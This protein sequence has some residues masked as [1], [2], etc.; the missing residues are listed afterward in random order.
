MGQIAQQLASNSQASGTLP[1]GTVTNPREHNTVNVVTTRSGKS[2]EENDIE[3][4]GLIEVDLEIKETKNQ[5][6]EVIPP[7]VKEKEKVPKP[8]APEKSSDDD[9]RP[10]VQV[11]KNPGQPRSTDPP[12]SSQSKKSKKNKRSAATEPELT[13]QPTQP[14][15][16]HSHQSKGHQGQKRKKHDSLSRSGEAKKKKHH[17]VLTLEAPSLDADTIVVDTSILNKVPDLA[18]GTSKSTI[19]PFAAVLE[20]ENP[21]VVLP[22][23]T[24][25]DA[26]G[27]PSHHVADYTPSSPTS[28]PSHQA[29]S[30]VTAGE[31][32]GFPIQISDSDSDSVTSPAT[33]MFSSSTSSDSSL[34]SASLPLQDSRGPR[35]DGIIKTQPAQT[36]PL[37]TTSPSSSQGL[38]IKPL[39]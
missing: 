19:T 9:E 12:V 15:S 24:Q 21:D 13:P 33:H 16:Q 31:F 32:I 29:P 30:V 37:S 11:L 6:E 36:T 23:P 17:K 39:L 34:S 25:G 3:K 5:D 2:V 14:S 28:S 38:A 27:E 8:A 18:V 26:S 35:D 22:T 10:I 1:S 7:P 4:D 20:E